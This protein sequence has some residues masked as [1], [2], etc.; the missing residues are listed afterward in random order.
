MPWIENCGGNPR[1]YFCLY[2]TYCFSFQEISEANEEALLRDSIT[3]FF[4]QFKAS[5][6]SVFLLHVIIGV[7]PDKGCH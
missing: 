3:Q 6:V 7:S 1:G 4:M 5:F 2:V